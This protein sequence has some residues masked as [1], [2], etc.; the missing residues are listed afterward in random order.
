MTY[1]LPTALPIDDRFEAKSITVKN[2]ENNDCEQ[3]AKNTLQ[4]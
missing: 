4:I 2:G 1:A 3:I